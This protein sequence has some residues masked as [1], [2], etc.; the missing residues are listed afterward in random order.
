MKRRVLSEAEV[1]SGR[2]VVIEIRVQD[3]LQM[4]GV[5]HDDVVQT[6]SSDRADDPLHI[7]VLP[8]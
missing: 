4:R 6:L 5:P 8:W 3:A 1:R 2:V 7:S